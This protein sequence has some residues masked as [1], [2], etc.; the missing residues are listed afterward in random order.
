ML[1]ADAVIVSDAPPQVDSTPLRTAL[2][3][4]AGQLPDDLLCTARRWLAEGRTTEVA[5]SVAFAAVHQRVPL[6][7]TNQDALV[8]A[9]L[10]AGED[11][12][13][14]RGLAPADH[15]PALPY[16][17]GLG[18]WSAEDTVDDAAVA[19]VSGEPGA[20]GLWRA[21]RAP[22]D[23]APWPEPKRVYLVQA[24]EETDLVALTARAQRAICAAGEPHPQVEIYC[25]GEQLPAYQYTV[26]RNGELLWVRPA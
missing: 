25:Y 12:V 1:V 19:A 13:A 23:G 11:P 4:L 26:R 18:G 22:I 21:W 24:A 20:E 9:L 7:E 15:P 8:R 5:R 3:A 14:L 10:S 6:T 16:T 17:F 2:A